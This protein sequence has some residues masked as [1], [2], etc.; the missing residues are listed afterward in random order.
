MVRTW[1]LTHELLHVLWYVPIQCG[2]LSNTFA[3]GNHIEQWAA[4]AV[5]NMYASDNNIC[6]DTL[7]H[8]PKYS[9][10]NRLHALIA[11]YADVIAYNPAQMNK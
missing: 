8:E 1:R 6:P 5:T 7:P 4:S 2:F 3:G 11:A 9:H 10:L